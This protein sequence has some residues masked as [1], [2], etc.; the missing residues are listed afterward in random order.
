MALE[1][2]QLG[3]NP[4]M[5]YGPMDTLAR[6]AKAARQYR[7]LTQVAASELAGVKQ[8]DISKIERGETE[9]P[10]GLLALSRAYACDPDWLDTGDGLAPWEQENAGSDTKTPAVGRRSTLQPIL[11]WEHLDDLPEGEFVLIPRLDVRLSAGGGREQV[12]IVFVEKQP[13]AFRADWIRKK[14][15]K[16]KKLASMTADGDSMEDRI[17]HGDALVVDTSQTDIVD[18]KVYAIWYD[19]GER[20]KRLFRLPG[21]GL[22]IQ[23]DNPRHPTIEVAPAATEHV[24]II[25]RIVHVAGEGGL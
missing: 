17:Q 12:E 21:G 11:A 9:R 8:S 10:Q 4:A 7:N 6:R 3:L 25:G 5:D 18:G 13:Q 2:I 1:N 20:V 16:P 14:H 15:L 22:R 23:S 24:R 19:G